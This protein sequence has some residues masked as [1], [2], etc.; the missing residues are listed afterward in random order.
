MQLGTCQLSWMMEIEWTENELRMRR[1]HST[2]DLATGELNWTEKNVL[3]SRMWYKCSP[4]TRQTMPLYDYL[5]PKVDLNANLTT[6]YHCF[7][8]DD[9]RCGRFEN[10]ESDHHYESNPE[11]EVLF[12]IESNLEASQ[13][14]TTG[15]EPIDSVPISNDLT[16]MILCKWCAVLCNYTVISDNETALQGSEQCK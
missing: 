7:T 13:V 8:K 10:F 9:W 1:Q 6:A 15:V 5:T 12:E 4:K 14:P 16:Y 3:K 2:N 11:S